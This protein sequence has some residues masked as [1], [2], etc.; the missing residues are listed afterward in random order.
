[1][2]A[3]YEKT[4]NK[5]K[6]RLIRELGDNIDSIV[7]YG[8]VARN[9]AREDSDID[10]LVVIEKDDLYKTVSDISYEV[11][12]KNGTHTTIF[13]A[14]PKELENYAKRGSPFLES[15][16]E[17]GV[18]LYDKGTFAKIRRSLIG[19]RTKGS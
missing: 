15:V 11:D 12:L 8:S 17:E 3:L 16:V 6:E 2:I 5:L 13:W 19:A 9:E 4:I 7:L 1:M 18:I 14:T 10:I